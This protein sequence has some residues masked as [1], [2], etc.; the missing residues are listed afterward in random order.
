MPDQTKADFTRKLLG[1]YR[2]FIAKVRG[3]RQEERTDVITTITSID[4]KHVEDCQSK[5]QKM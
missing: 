5:I 1:I 3:I 4:Q 2:G